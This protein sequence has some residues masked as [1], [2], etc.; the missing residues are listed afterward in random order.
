MLG[1]DGMRNALGSL[2]YTSAHNQFLNTM[3][4]GGL[5]LFLILIA[6]IYIVFDK[7]S[8]CEDKKDKLVGSVGMIGVLVT[9]LFETVLGGTQCWMLLYCVYCLADVSATKVEMRKS[10]KNERQNDG[11]RI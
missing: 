11:K 4:Q 10:I 6:M 9:M 2:S 5:I 1:D 7:L 8:K 3:L